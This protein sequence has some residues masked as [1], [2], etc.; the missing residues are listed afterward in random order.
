[1]KFEKEHTFSVTEL[2]RRVVF[3][4][5]SNIYESFSKIAEE[6]GISASL[7]LRKCMAKVVQDKGFQKELDIF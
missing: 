5:N 1:M 4:A 6:H 7:A 2:D 3:R